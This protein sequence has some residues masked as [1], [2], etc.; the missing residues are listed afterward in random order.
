MQKTENA[1]LIPSEA[2]IPILKGQ[3]VFIFKSGKAKEVK[4]KSGIRT[5]DRIQIMEGIVAGDTVITTGIMQISD[6]STVK[7]SKKK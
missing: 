7:I 6:G 3:K 2:L 5:T 1:L 4:V